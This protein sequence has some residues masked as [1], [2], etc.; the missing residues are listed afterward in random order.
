MVIVSDCPLVI[1]PSKNS[2]TG[3]KSVTVNVDLANQPVEDRM[4]YRLT[5]KILDSNGKTG[6]LEIYNSFSLNPEPRRKYLVKPWKGFRR[7][8]GMELLT[9]DEI[10]RLTPPERLALIAQLWEPR[11]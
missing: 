6:L 11:S 2:A 1:A 7:L 4:M 10:G 3:I 9:P 5:W 8:E